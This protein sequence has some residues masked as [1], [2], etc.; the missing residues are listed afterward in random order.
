MTTQLGLALALSAG[1]TGKLGRAIVEALVSEGRHDVLVLARVDEA[2]KK[3]LGARLVSADYSSIDALASLL[4]T[5]NVDISTAT[6]RYIPN[7]WG[8]KYT[9]RIAS[10]FPIAQA[11]LNVLE[12]VEST[13]LEYTAVLNGYFADYWFVPNVKSYQGPLPLVIDVANN[14]AAIPGSGNVPV[15][16][17]H[18]FDIARL[19]PALLTLPKWE[20]ESY[21]IG[22]KVTWNEFLQ[23]I[24]DAK[25]AKFST[26]YDPMEKLKAGQITELPSQRQMYPF[27]PKEMLQGLFAAFGRMFE[28][29]EFDLKP[30]HTL[31]DDFPEI[32]PRGVRQLGLDAWKQT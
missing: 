18:T 17:T 27:F 24:E 8:I 21:I 6:K 15:A 26:V 30:F 20:K 32:K 7:I 23:I 13:S 25:G 4:D 16:F 22:D 31:N 29:G 10:Y 2:K 28:E 1:G 12:A 5:N 19:I 9:A 3:E 14:T 11:K